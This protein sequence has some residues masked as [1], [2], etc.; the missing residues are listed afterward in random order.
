MYSVTLKRLDGTEET[1][2]YAYNVPESESFLELATNER[3]RERVGTDVKLLIQEVGDFDWVHGEQAGQ[4]IHDFVLILL[5]AF[6]LCE[7]LLALRLSYH[8]KTATT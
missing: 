3:L 8:P 1:R 7:Q 6:L 2:R 4:E 5:L